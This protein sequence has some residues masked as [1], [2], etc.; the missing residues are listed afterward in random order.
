VYVSNI[1]YQLPQT[2]SDFYCGEWAKI[3]SK[4]E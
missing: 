1:G 2:G 3:R 4:D